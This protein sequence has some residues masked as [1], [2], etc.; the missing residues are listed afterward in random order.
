MQNKKTLL[1]LSLT[2]LSLTAC[3]N[4]G[5]SGGGESSGAGEGSK[6]TP[7]ASSS[8]DPNLTIYGYNANSRIIGT[9]KPDPN[10]P[11]Q[12][13]PHAEENLQFGNLPTYRH[14]DK[15]DVPYVSVSE[16]A[17]AMGDALPN[18]L[19]PGMTT[20]KK[21]DGFH[22]YSPDKKGDLI[23][24]A[25]KDIIKLKSGQS[26]AK[27]ITGDNNNIAGDY[28]AYRG[29][30]IKESDKTKV[31]RAD[32][33]EVAEYDTFDFGK[34][35]FDIVSQGGEC[36]VPLEAFTKVLLRDVSLDMAY[37]G[38]DFYTNVSESSF[39]ASWVYSSKGVFQGLSGIYEPS[40]TKGPDEAYRF[41]FGTKRAS[42]ADPKVLEDYTRFLVLGEDGSGYSMLCKGSE[43]NP[44]A[45][46]SDTESEYGY[47]WKKVGETLHIDVKD[48]AG[49][50]GTLCV[51]LDETRFLSGSISSAVSSYNY[52]VLRFVFDTIY[53]LKGIKKYTDATAFFKAAGVDE[54]LKSNK[55]AVYTEAF[56]KLVGYIDDGHTGFNNLTPYTA[57]SDLDKVGE[58]TKISRNGPRLTKLTTDGQ[59]YMKSKMET[60]KRI[61]PDGENPDGD[62]NYYQG[63]RFSSDKETAII[64]FN[65]FANNAEQI[66]NMAEQ[67]PEGYT[68]EESDYVRN[69]RSAMITSTP[70]G[71]NQAFKILDIVNKSD[72]V[73]KNVVVDLSTNGGGEIAIMPYLAAFFSDD[74]TYVI[75][76]VHSKAIREYHYKV[77]INGDGTFGGTG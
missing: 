55:P 56:A 64:S 52:D 66:R 75:Q 67:F 15:G 50:I 5:T 54:G 31:Y 62:T 12:I 8:L 6:S 40:K 57:D 34:Y 49:T 76:D 48:N 26:F 20:E 37:N 72:K 45:A 24:D 4:A 21:D 65:G 71:F 25:E 13:L 7:A 27:P 29:K 58:Y 17:K 1:I 3:G 18:V 42:E 46:V 44:S 41:Q 43:L 30:S 47:M 51:H 11:A 10:N 9:P 22:L 68:R 35:N 14:K 38:V 39:L 73:V 33:G 70:D 60:T 63:L 23:L 28:C 32:G 19:T 77:D 2:L 61:D 74:P 36:Y 16:L 53:G 59:K 69:A